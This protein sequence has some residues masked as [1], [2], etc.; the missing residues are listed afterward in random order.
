MPAQMALYRFTEWIGRWS[1][2]D[3]FVVAIVVALVRLGNLMS[4]DPGPGGM[5]FAA[6]VIL[7]MLA[8]H[9]FDPRLIWDQQQRRT[10]DYDTLER[11]A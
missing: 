8:A 2:I 10:D 7:T 9:S 4:I 3:V 6:V 11:R 1:M 5:A